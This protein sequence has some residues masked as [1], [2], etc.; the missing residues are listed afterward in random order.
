MIY[1]IC[2]QRQ[3]SR[4]WQLGRRSKMITHWDVVICYGTAVFHMM[5]LMAVVIICVLAV[6]WV[7]RRTRSP[8]S[9]AATQQQQQQQQR[10]WCAAATMYGSQRWLAASAGS[11]QWRRLRHGLALV[12]LTVDERTRR[13]DAR[14]DGQTDGRSVGRGSTRRHVLGQPA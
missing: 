13:S 10:W 4:R 7:N 2:Y 11:L 3:I 5:T 9:P 12:A 6:K 14:T 8:S 1:M